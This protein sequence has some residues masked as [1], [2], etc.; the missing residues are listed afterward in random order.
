MNW[1]WNGIVLWNPILL[2]F[3]MPKADVFLFDVFLAKTKICWLFWLVLVHSVRFCKVTT[4]MWLWQKNSEI[5][6]FQKIMLQVGFSIR[7]FWIGEV[8]NFQPRM[9]GFF[10]ASVNGTSVR[11]C[12]VRGC[13]Y[14]IPISLCLSLLGNCKG[15][16]CWRLAWSKDKNDICKLF[17]VKS[18]LWQKYENDLSKSKVDKLKQNN[19]FTNYLGYISFT[20]SGVI[21]MVH[22]VH[23]CK[24]LALFWGT[25]WM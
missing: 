11:F 21:V 7:V 20:D 6:E 16:H 23:E 4:W 17:S 14:V 13:D 10:Y 19:L 18:N 24:V 5:S 9:F 15:S 12:K 3:T 2:H 1:N 25:E 8:S 22:S